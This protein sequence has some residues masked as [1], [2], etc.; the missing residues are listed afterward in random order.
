MEAVRCRKT[1]NIL[2]TGLKIYVI[3]ADR[4]KDPKTVIMDPKTIFFCLCENIAAEQLFKVISITY[5]HFYVLRGGFKDSFHQSCPGILTG[6]IIL[7]NPVFPC[8]V[9]IVMPL[10]VG[11]EVSGLKGQNHICVVRDDLA[12]LFH[13]AH[14]NVERNINQSLHAQR[15]SAA[16][17]DL[18]PFPANFR[19]A[20]VKIIQ[21]GLWQLRCVDIIIKADIAVHDP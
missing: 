19:K 8:S 6:G 4:R 10:P 14:D 1:G 12:D 5:S 13:V 16:K 11:A 7:S 2:Q 9:Y 15:V 21:Q 3:S 20:A 18:H 17:D